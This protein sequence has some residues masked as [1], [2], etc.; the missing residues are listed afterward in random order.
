MARQQ[1][2][3]FKSHFINRLRAIFPGCMIL[4]NDAEYLQGIPDLLLLWEDRWA[5]FE[6]KRKPPT[7][8]RDFE[9][10]QEYYIEELDR[11]SFAACVFPENEEEVLD[12][13]QRQFQ[14]R[15]KTR[16]S[17]R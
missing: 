8:P 3:T 2:G 16:V 5:I 6:V 15:R 11:M 13:L 1:E 9:P 7:S 14:T 12:A 4:K 10:N 17:Q